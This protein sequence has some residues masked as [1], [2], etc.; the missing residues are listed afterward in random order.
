[1]SDSSLPEIIYDEQELSVWKYC[2]P[3][4]KGMFKTY[5]CKEFNWTI[6]QFE[7]HID[8][9]EDSIPQLDSISKFL[10]A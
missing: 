8:F 9:K 6:E 1:M 3:R 4:L 10:Q 5:A 2:Y 7:K